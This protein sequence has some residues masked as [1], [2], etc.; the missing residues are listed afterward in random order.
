MTQAEYMAEKYK[1][2][3]DLL[4]A[5]NESPDLDVNQDW[6]NEST[7]WTFSDGS[8]IA[9]SGPDVTVKDAL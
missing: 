5:L 8:Q 9:I 2:A 1:G 7:T 3:S 4:T 6:D